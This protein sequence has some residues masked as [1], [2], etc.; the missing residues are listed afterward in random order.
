[1]ALAA[2]LVL[3][4]EPS[5]LHGTLSL[6]NPGNA[7]MALR[8]LR[9]T[10]TGR[11]RD[12]LAVDLPRVKVRPGAR[13]DVALSL[14]IG[15]TTPPGHYTMSLPIDGTEH[16]AQIIVTE[17]VDLEIAPAE[18]VLTGKP[19]TKIDKLMAFHNHGNVPATVP[20]V[21]AVQLD[22]DQLHCR[23]Q[24]AALKALVDSERRL[25][26]LIRALSDSYQ[27]ELD[28]F[29]PLRVF[30]DALS[31]PPGETRS[32]TWT[33]QIPGKIPTGVDATAVI[34]ILSDSVT[35]RLRAT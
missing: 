15:P 4:G 6:H 16:P 31:V 30:N 13:R 11:K 26:D 22:L 23:A 19:G 1:M 18:L 12:K 27:A 24:R 35:V 10:E 21:G 20:A 9:L 2:P 8:D 3:A 34:P 25:D 5:A 7:R 28:S 29:A 32:Q 33:F 17:V 14:A